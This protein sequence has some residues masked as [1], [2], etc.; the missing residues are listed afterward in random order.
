MKPMKEM[1]ALVTGASRGIGA[2]AAVLLAEEGM[3][4]VVH[5]HAAR[6]K[7]E[8]TARACERRGARATVVRADLRDRAE[9]DRL[10]GELDAAGLSPDILV[11]NAGVSHYGL[12]TDVTEQD[13]D[14][15]VGVNLK[16]MF[17]LTQLLAPAMVGRRYGRI[18]NV[19]SVWGVAGASCEVLYSLTK[20]GVNA[21]TKALAKELAPSGVTVNAVAPGAV[22]TDMMRDFSEDELAALRAEIPAGRLARPEEIASLIRFLASPE[23]G[24][25]TGQIISPN[26]GWLT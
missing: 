1:T 13:W 5:Y 20:G 21:F 17:R 12:F 15:V 9:L 16:G 14:D 6:D 2:A 19:S 11:N 4:I 24:Y 3:H 7:A 22:E 23:S 18:I 26:G 25:I 8:A 10:K